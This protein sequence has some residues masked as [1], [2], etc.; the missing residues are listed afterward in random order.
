MSRVAHGDTVTDTMQSD[1][2]N[3]APRP[4]EALKAAR[5]Y[6]RRGLAVLPLDGKIPT[7]RHG[8]LDAANDDDTLVK[9]F[10]NERNVGIA[11]TPG[12]VVVDVDPRNGGDVTFWWWIEEHGDDWLD[13]PHAATGGGGLHYWFRY[14]DRELVKTVAGVDLVRGNKYVVAPPS[15]TAAPYRWIVPLGQ[16]IDLLPELPGW[17]LELTT[18]PERAADPPSRALTAS[19]GDRPGD[20]WAAETTWA[21]LLTGDGWTLEGRIG[22]EER[23]TRPG[24][25]PRDGMS[26]TTG[27]SAADTLHVFTSSMPG[28]D[29]DQNYSKLGYLAAMRYG[30]DHTAAARSLVERG[31]GDPVIEYAGVAGLV[32]PAALGA[33]ASPGAVTAPLDPFEAAVALEVLR[34]TVRNEAAR[35]VATEGAVDLPAAIDGASLLATEDDPLTWRIADLLSIGDN[36]LLAAERKA[37]KTTLAMNLVVAA[38]RGEHFLDKVTTPV[39][40][41]V[42]YWDAELGRRRFRSWLRDMDIGDRAAA[43][44]YRDFRALPFPAVFDDDVAESIAAELRAEGVQLWVIDPAVHAIARWPTTASSA[45]SDNVAVTQFTNRLDEIKVAAGVSEL[46]VIHHAGKDGTGRGRGASRWEDWP[47]VIW[48][49]SRSKAAAGGSTMRA[50]GRDVELDAVDL[51]YSKTT[52]RIGVAHP[53]WRAGIDEVV[54]AIT[55]QGGRITGVT[56]LEGYLIGDGAAR[57]RKWHD[58]IEAGEVARQ[59]QQPV[60]FTLAGDLST[61]V[62]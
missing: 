35:R 22:A 38:L 33:T 14:D 56:R 12:V 36:L 10:T 47:D 54:A 30:G 13:G 16:G 25:S 57:N 45:E 23:W 44:S 29:A 8:V 50:L 51:S 28:L 19:A 5:Y 18:P 17:L 1:A 58:A 59:G 46:V 6:A 52:K 31:Y 43:L 32:A 55:E 20:R 15:V 61:M 49:L 37:G 39:E 40:G 2:E 48:T 4:S 3:A 27:H 34:I 21:E 53:G 41:A 11:M 7:T 60:I 42:A 62:V 9:W 24:K 26:A